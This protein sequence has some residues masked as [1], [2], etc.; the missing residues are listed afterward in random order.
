VKSQLNGE[1]AEAQSKQSRRKKSSSSKNDASANYESAASASP[2]GNDASAASGPGRNF[3]KAPI[4]GYVS[5]RD[6]RYYIMPAHAMPVTILCQLSRCQLHITEKFIFFFIIVGE[7][8]HWRPS[9]MTAAPPPWMTALLQLSLREVRRLKVPDPPTSPAT[10]FMT[11][12][13]APFRCCR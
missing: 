9:V 8:I 7:Q 11:T 5:S 4:R 2:K 1:G 6:A 10:P 3:R 12:L 13:S